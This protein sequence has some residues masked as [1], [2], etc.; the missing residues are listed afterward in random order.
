MNKLSINIVTVLLLFSGTIQ[1]VPTFLN[2]DLLWSC[3]KIAI[4]SLL[5]FGFGYVYAKVKQ[6]Q[7]NGVAEYEKICDYLGLKIEGSGQN[8]SITLCPTKTIFLFDKGA[9]T[10]SPVGDSGMILINA[11]K[12]P[13]AWAVNCCFDGDSK[14]HYPIMR[15]NKIVVDERLKSKVKTGQVEVIEALDK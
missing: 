7:K 5:T 4:P 2:K 11:A 10:V 13:E 9:F 15:N 8:C 6:K 1:P 14:H 12:C 3:A